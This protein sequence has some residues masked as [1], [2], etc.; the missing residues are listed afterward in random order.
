LLVKGVLTRSNTQGSVRIVRRIQRAAA[1]AANL[2]ILEIDQ[3]L[4]AKTMWVCGSTRPGVRT[5]PPMFHVL[6]APPAGT[7]AT[8][9]IHAT[10]PLVTPTAPLR[11]RPTAARRP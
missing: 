9:P 8:R 1:A 11:T 6:P 10:L 4:L 3:P 7:S 2:E 5:L